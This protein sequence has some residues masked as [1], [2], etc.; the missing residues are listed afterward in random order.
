MNIARLKVLIEKVSSELDQLE[1]TGKIT[2]N[3]RISYAPVILE[4]LL[5]DDWVEVS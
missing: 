4:R 5:R 1:A 3:D 2:A